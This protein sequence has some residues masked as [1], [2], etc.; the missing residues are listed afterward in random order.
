[1][2]IIKLC[3]LLLTVVGIAASLP[4]RTLAQGA[5]GDIPFERRTAN[6]PTTVSAVESAASVPQFMVDPFWPKSL[7][8]N[9]IIGQVSGVHVDSNDLVWIVHRPRSLSER[10]VGATLDPPASKCCYPAPPVL[11]FDQSGNLVRA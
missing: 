7:P 1:M 2:S 10:E 3:P 11:A 9:W 5:V 4:E 6:S 8:N